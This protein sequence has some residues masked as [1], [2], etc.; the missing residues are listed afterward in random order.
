MGNLVVMG[1]M[2][3]CSFGAAPS[4][5]VVLPQG[6]PVMGGGPA[7][8]TIMD[9][10]PIANI[11]PFGMCNTPSNPTVAAAT[12]AALGVLTPMPCV[13]V[14]AA[15]WAPGCPTVLINN[16]PALN[17]SSKCMCSWGGV[18]SI[19]FAGQVTVQVP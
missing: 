15:P 5:L 3:T 1:A 8:A 14:T 2:M 12:A 7:A 4:S 9:F 10:K 11:P 13:P 19:T 18:I 17:D 16:F 6:P